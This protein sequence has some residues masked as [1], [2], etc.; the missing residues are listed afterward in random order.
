MLAIIGGTGLY[1]LQGLDI[2]ERLGGDTPFGTPSGEIL[3]GRLHGRS[4]LFL[5]RH[6]AGHRL[7]PHEV[8][9]RANIFAL[10][11]A[12]ATQLLGFSAVGSLA[13]DV[14]PGTLAMPEQYIDWTRGQRDRTFFGGGVAAH[15]STA[16]PVSPALVTAVQAAGGRAGVAVKRGLTYACVEGPRLGTQAESHLLR[17]VGCHLVGMTNVPEVFLAREAQMAYATVGLV[18]DY[19]C[20]LEDPALHV[21]VGAIFERYGQTLALA[22]QVL[23]ALLLADPPQPEAESR[24]ALRSALLTPDAAMS[25]DQ[26]EWLRVLRA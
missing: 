24:E 11:R 10:K 23:D 9:Y 7:L 5:A 15:V 6:G 4:L 1:D 17:Q 14:A 18:T 26:Q 8:N 3:K 19:D 12:G 22:R 16:R 21:S 13:L 25:P 20:W 2:D